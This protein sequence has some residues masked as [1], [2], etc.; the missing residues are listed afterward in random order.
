[1]PGSAFA[2]LKAK[3]VASVPSGPSK[4]GSAPAQKKKDGP[5]AEEAERQPRSAPGRRR[6][7]RQPWQE[8]AHWSATK[9]ASTPAHWLSVP[10][11]SGL[12]WAAARLGC[13]RESEQ[14]L[15]AGTRR[16]RTSTPRAPRRREARATAGRISRFS[17]STVLPL[18]V[19]GGPAARPA[20]P[21]GG[22]G[23]RQAAGPGAGPRRRVRRGRALR[24]SAQMRA[25]ARAAY[26]A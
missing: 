8:A 17:D 23:A 12:A 22:G 20:H 16:G 14:R 26:E 19:L 3:Q 13:R 7:R 10:K 1:M 25:H 15:A 6:R 2:N 4:P 11:R 18:C 21:G 5:G 24:R 9:A